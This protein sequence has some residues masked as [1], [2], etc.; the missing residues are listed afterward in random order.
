MQEP[1][2]ILLADDDNEDQ[3]LFIDAI[4]RCD[5]NVSVQTFGNGR[6]VISFL[7]RCTDSEL[8]DLI[9]LDYKMPI[10]NGIDVLKLL[11]DDPR[12]AIIPS[13]IWSSS[14]QGEHVKNSIDNGARQYFV[15]PNSDE[16]LLTLAGVLLALGRKV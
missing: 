2:K 4:K 8:P 14:K 3:E 1:I 5:A 6:A 7:E 9:I 13:V 12:L 15:K 11:R 16:E 10:L